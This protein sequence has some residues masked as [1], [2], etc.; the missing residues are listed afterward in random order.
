MSA[1][2]QRGENEYWEER[3]RAF[4]REGGALGAV[5]SYG[6]PAFYNWEIQL[7]QK[8][9]LKRHLR[10][11]GMTV[12]DI[13]CG[14]GRW[15]RMAATTA[16]SVTGVDLSPTM[17]EEARRRAVEDRVAERCRFIVGDAASFH[18]DQTFDRVIAVTVLQHILAPRRLTDAVANI[19][20]HLSPGGRAVI[21]EAAPSR[22]NSR[23][24]T[25]VFRA[26]SADYYLHE[27]SSAGLT[28][29]EM[30]GVDPAPFKTLILPH[31]RSMP[32]GVRRAALFAVTAASLPVDLLLARRFAGLSWHKVFI[33]Q[34]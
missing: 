30:T 34:K 16:A 13:G 28:C 18:L 14:I 2:P 27:F 17:I 11:G 32:R 5:C 22:R 8:L 7:T 23:C 3:A 15:S 1:V 31:Y 29:V 9:A 26:R 25:Q 12:L 24:D 20:R 6:M 10:V 4:A 21:L 19:S 33:L